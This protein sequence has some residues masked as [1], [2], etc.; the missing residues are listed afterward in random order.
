MRSLIGG[1]AE[2]GHT[3][4]M[5]DEPSH[6]IDLEERVDSAYPCLERTEPPDVNETDD[7]TFMS[8]QNPN[9]IIGR[10]LETC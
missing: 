2:I 4:T 1:M 7:V 10:Y 6:E 3:E 5:S 9:N 8:P